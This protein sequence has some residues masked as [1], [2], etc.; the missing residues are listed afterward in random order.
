[1]AKGSVGGSN[2]RGSN[3]WGGNSM[4]VWVGSIGRVAKTIVVWVSIGR[5]E[6]GGVCLGL[7]LSVSRSLS[8]KSVW[9]SIAI[10]SVSVSVSI[11][12]IS[13]ISIECISIRLWLSI[14][15]S[16]AVIAMVGVRVSVIGKGS[17]SA[18]NRDVG[19]LYKIFS[20]KYVCEILDVKSAEFTAPEELH[21]TCGL[22]VQH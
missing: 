15:R 22:L 7:W 6:E 9:I 18:G 16:L 13:I 5:V 21:S 17:S 12:S 4:G 20:C 8:V 3:N 19:S 1:M 11:R 10:S 2:S 14:G